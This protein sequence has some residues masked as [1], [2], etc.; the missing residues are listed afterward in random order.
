MPKCIPCSSSISR[1]LIVVFFSLAANPWLFL[2]DGPP[3]LLPH[4]GLMVDL[5]RSDPSMSTPF[6]PLLSYLSAHAWHG[7]AAPHHD[8]IIP[9]GCHGGHALLANSRRAGYCQAPMRHAAKPTVHGMSLGLR[10]L[11]FANALDSQ[12]HQAALDFGQRM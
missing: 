1:A 10:L 2:F 4:P 12:L 7:C 3:L 8:H 5:S 9:K 6:P 11:I